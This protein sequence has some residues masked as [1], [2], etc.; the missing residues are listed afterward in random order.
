MTESC[1]GWI[2]IYAHN[3]SVTGDQEEW[4]AQLEEVVVLVRKFCVVS[5]ERCC[6]EW[7]LLAAKDLWDNT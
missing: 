5:G 3:G 6:S 1:M 4:L 7:T 2:S